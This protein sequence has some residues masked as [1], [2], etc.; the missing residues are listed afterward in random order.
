MVALT[1]MK[2]AAAAPYAAEFA[3]VHE[4]LPGAGIVWLDELRARAMNRCAVASRSVAIAMPR[5]RAR[6]HCGHP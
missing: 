1:S 3:R 6:A 5:L 2:D 4:A